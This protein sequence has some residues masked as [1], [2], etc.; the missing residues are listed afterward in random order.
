MFVRNIWRRK[1]PSSFGSISVGMV[2]SCHKR[3]FFCPWAK[4]LRIYHQCLPKITLLC[5][6]HRFSAMHFAFF[7]ISWENGLRSQIFLFAIQISACFPTIK[8]KVWS[9]PMTIDCMICKTIWKRNTNGWTGCVAWNCR[10]SPFGPPLGYTAGGLW[11]YA[12]ILI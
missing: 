11:S 9:K 6:K 8:S 12:Q 5:L 10:C 3:R 4:I 2:D 7:C 1:K